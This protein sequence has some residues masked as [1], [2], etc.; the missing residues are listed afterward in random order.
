M[1]ALE[2]AKRA[3]VIM[4]LVPDEKQAKIYDESIKPN[5]EKGNTLMFAHGL[6]VHYKQIVPH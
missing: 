1:T 3:D 5:L 2:A 6:N 4:I